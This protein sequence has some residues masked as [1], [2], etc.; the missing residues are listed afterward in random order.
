MQR[1]PV[2]RRAVAARQ[3]WVQRRL[4]KRSGPFRVVIQGDASPST[5]RLIRAVQARAAQ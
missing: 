5:L 2:N 3:S 4:A 1:K